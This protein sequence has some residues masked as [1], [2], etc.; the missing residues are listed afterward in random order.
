MIRLLLVPMNDLVPCIP[1]R[2]TV[3]LNCR[4]VLVT[5]RIREVSCQIVLTASTHSRRRIETE[6]LFVIFES[7]LTWN[8]R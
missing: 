6:L 3:M 7:Y 4:L 2:S 1:V 8:I 5:R